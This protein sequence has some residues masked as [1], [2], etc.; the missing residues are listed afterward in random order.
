MSQSLIA[1]HQYAGLFLGYSFVPTLFGIKKTQH[2]T[3]ILLNEKNIL[4]Y[5]MNKTLNKTLK[6][7][8]MRGEI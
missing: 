1:T 5:E 8:K 7:K 2:E 4:S 3:L 6:R